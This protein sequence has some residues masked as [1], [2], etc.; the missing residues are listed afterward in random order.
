MAWAPV[1]ARQRIIDITVKNIQ[2]YLEG[3]PV[4]VVN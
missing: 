4:N 1:E 3:K 2:G